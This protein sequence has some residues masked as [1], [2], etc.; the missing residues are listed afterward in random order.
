MRQDAA[1]GSHVSGAVRSAAAHGVAIHRAMRRAMR[2]GRVRPL[3]VALSTLVLAFALGACDSLLGPAGKSQPPGGGPVP[4]GFAITG[5]ATPLVPGQTARLQGRLLLQ[6]LRQLSVD[7]QDVAFAVL[8]DS[9]A[10]FTTPVSTS[11]EVDGR[12]VPIVANDG[13]QLTGALY[14]DTAI[15]LE[16]GET[17]VLPAAGVPCIQLP[18]DAADYLLTILSTTTA[19]IEEQVL[20]LRSVTAAGAAVAAGAAGAP[21]SSAA[22]Q[23]ALHGS[24]R[25]APDVGAQ[26]AAGLAPA[27]VLQAYHDYGGIDVG[28]V[29]DFVDWNNPAVVHATHR[30]DVPTVQVLI[31]AV[32]DGHIV[33][34]DTRVPGYEQFA[35][36]TM[37]T[38][39]RQ[40][41][42]ISDRVALPAMRQVI[43]A[44]LELPAGAGG[45]MV[46]ILEVMPA[47]TSGSISASELQPRAWAGDFFRIRLNESLVRNGFRAETIAAIMIH[48]AAHLADALRTSRHP[49]DLAQAQSRGWFAEALAVAVED[50]AAHLALGGAPQTPARP[51]FSTAG[52]PRAD[53]AYSIGLTAHRFSP[54][55]PPG[56]GSGAAGPGAYERGARIVRYAMERLGDDHT[57][58]QRLV[59]RAHNDH[60]RFDEMLAAWSID[61][62]ARELGTTA[63][64]VLERSMFAD[65]L[66]DLVPTAAVAQ[67]NVPQTLKWDRTPQYDR[68]YDYHAPGHVIRR[69]TAFQAHVTVPGGGY[70]FW[71]L[72]G[73]GQG[74]SLEA[75]NVQL[76]PHHRVQ[77]TRMR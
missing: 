5:L 39:V 73:D 71:Y 66:D 45:R 49:Y 65:L 72:P 16:V 62:I 42:E 46:S 38:R 59:A 21:W 55:G 11:C 26:L 56:S 67:Y 33:G 20:S 29:V 68:G 35:D 70:A 31:L 40:A 15:R 24:A 4:P 77:L 64:A 75:T 1:S 76:E 44:S 36:P 41:A 10:T 19:P 23:A 22:V 50:V 12:S 61:A 43:D 47:S 8:D 27:A 17:R 2:T 30:E 52:V 37:R 14:L 7:G 13:R 57:L 25:H 60:N 6:H 58:Y 53:I 18:A 48:E 32:T 9:T 51:A 54:W 74:L 3:A 28:E 63:A 34:V 69:G